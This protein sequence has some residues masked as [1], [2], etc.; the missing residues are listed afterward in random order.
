[1]HLFYLVGIN[2]HMMLYYFK[3]GDFYI[4]SVLSY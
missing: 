3:Y 4:V 1:M 2:K